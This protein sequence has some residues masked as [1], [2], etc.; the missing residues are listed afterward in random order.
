MKP[1]YPQEE[2]PEGV[3][4]FNEKIPPQTNIGSQIWNEQ[5]ETVR[6]R[7]KFPEVFNDQTREPQQTRN[8]R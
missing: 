7:D 8:T 4:H 6:R 5:L 3:K 1:E 2:F